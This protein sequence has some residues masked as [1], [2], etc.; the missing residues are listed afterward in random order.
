MLKNPTPHQI[1]LFTALRTGLLVAALS[2]L[3]LYFLSWPEWV[4]ALAIPLV[5]VIATYFISYNYIKVYI[6]RKIKVIYKTIHDKKL[7]QEEKKSTS[8]DMNSNII[9]EVEKDVQEWADDHEK[10]INR[11][12]S[13][14]EYRRKYIGD[15]SHELKTPIFN[16]QGYIY[17]LLE[18]GLKD[19]R[20]NVSYLK[21]A[22]NN[23]DRLQ[24]IVQDLESI[25]RLESGEL[26]LDLQVFDIKEL[27]EE[28]F[29]DFE[30]KA[31]RKKIGLEFKEGAATNYKVK[32]DREYIRQVLSNLVNNSIK[33][34]TENG[35]TKI[36]FYDMDKN[37]L[38]EVADNGIGIPQKH[39]PHV[40]DRF[41]RVDKSRSRHQ[42]G[43]G[44]GLSIVKHIIEA[45][46]QTINVRSTASLGS[47]FGF[48]LEKVN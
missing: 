38:I 7:T 10:E 41:Y 37:I 12:K 17:T 30:I 40:F 23:I 28:V 22:A 32:A 42:G 15:I 4:T 24:T 39:L 14:A 21:K 36:G 27:T 5:A 8:F 3:L 6:L 44:L 2:I 48:T 35:K 25:S 34:G 43:S 47:T 33:Y 1:A 11:Y 46:H 13:W 9:N 29:E 19:E 31:A 18:G 26:V 16:I 20:I 45:H